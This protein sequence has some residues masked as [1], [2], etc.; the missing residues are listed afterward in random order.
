MVIKYQIPLNYS[1][2]KFVTHEWN[3]SYIDYPEEKNYDET[4]KDASVHDRL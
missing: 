2:K 4:F 3:Q 1:Q